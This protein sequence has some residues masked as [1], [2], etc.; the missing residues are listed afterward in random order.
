MPKVNYKKSKISLR[1]NRL[2]ERNKQ[3]KQVDDAVRRTATEY[4]AR[5]RRLQLRVKNIEDTI[6]DLDEFYHALAQFH[7]PD[8]DTRPV[9]QLKAFD[10]INPN[11]REVKSVLPDFKKLL[12]VVQMYNFIVLCEVTGAV[13]WDKVCGDL[14]DACHAMGIHP[15]IRQGSIHVIDAFFDYTVLQEAR[16]FNDLVTFKYR[17]GVGDTMVTSF[18]S[19][20]ERINQLN[21]LSLA[22]QAVDH[23]ENTIVDP[24]I[25]PELSQIIEDVSD[26]YID[27]N[28]LDWKWDDEET[29]PLKD[30]GFDAYMSQGSNESV[31]HAV[32]VA[33][34][35]LDQ[36][37]QLP[38][39]HPVSKID[40]IVSPFV[41]PTGKRHLKASEITPD[42]SSRWDNLSYEDRELALRGVEANKRRRRIEMLE[43]A[44]SSV[45]TKDPDFNLNS[46]AS[47]S[48]ATR[49]AHYRKP[50][51]AQYDAYTMAMIHHLEHQR[52]RFIDLYHEYIVQDY[53]YSIQND[54]IPN[55]QPPYWWLK[56]KGYIWNI[57]HDHAIAWY[58]GPDG[59]PLKKPGYTFPNGYVKG[60]PFLF[61]KWWLKVPIDKKKFGSA[62]THEA[63]NK[64]YAK[65]AHKDK[66][67][68]AYFD[69]RRMGLDPHFAGLDFG[70]NRI[71]SNNYDPDSHT[72]NP[73]S[74]QFVDN[75]LKN[76][77]NNY[78]TAYGKVGLLDGLSSGFKGTWHPTKDKV[79]KIR[80]GKPY[81]INKPDDFDPEQ[82]NSIFIA[83]HAEEF[84]RY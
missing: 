84:N 67:L 24:A 59:M 66:H 36:F 11:T 58:M 41:K 45:A 15:A 8:G 70:L 27:D 22:R 78:A 28:S 40:D 38:D 71:Y 42:I 72:I 68:R 43:K 1:E 5:I 44:K 79:F 31:R 56:K 46:S 64:Y 32:S 3:K 6:H 75:D 10:E 25:D 47:S 21:P 81:F 49:N 65:Y 51:F 13:D 63:F 29:S 60:T 7:N 74:F 55:F 62:N 19:E 17:T 48:S 30:E 54:E 80:F 20:I 73:R 9:N 4:T 33:P 57:P 23:I 61:D 35:I 34:D 2:I 83:A 82:H 14:V 77:F 76:S 18:D 12:E 69:A 26:K 52:K 50:D 16:V 37:L 39:T 53:V